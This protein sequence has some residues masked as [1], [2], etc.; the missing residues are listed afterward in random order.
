MAT[1]KVINSALSEIKKGITQIEEIVRQMHK[2][3]N[4]HD[5][6]VTRSGNY[7]LE[8]NNA[9][10]AA[11]LEKVQTVGDSLEQYIETLREETETLF[12]FFDY[13]D[14]RL[15]AAMNFIKA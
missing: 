6:D 14:P 12:S 2:E 13:G 1:K 8:Q 10:R 5:A 7:K 11:A 9:S 15:F 4:E 3:I